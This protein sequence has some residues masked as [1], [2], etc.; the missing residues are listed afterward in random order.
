[1]SEIAD[2]LD[3]LSKWLELAED[4]RK[5]G[6]T[7]DRGVSEGIRIARVSLGKRAAELRAQRSGPTY[8]LQ[9]KPAEVRAGQWWAFRDKDPEKVTSVESVGAANCV[10]FNDIDWEYSPVEEMRSADWHY[11]GD[12]PE[13]AT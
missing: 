12:G 8:K 6:N 7:F 3:R 1:M 2:E 5:F 11:Y 9:P 4:S 10:F 13:P